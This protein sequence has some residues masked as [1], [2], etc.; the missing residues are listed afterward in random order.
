MKITKGLLLTSAVRHTSPQGKIP[1][2]PEDVCR[3]CRLEGREIVSWLAV[4]SD[5]SVF[6]LCR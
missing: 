6:V 1:G 4:T 3:T 2:V 5:L